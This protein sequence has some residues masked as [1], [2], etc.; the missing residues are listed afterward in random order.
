LAGLFFKVIKQ[1]KPLVIEINVKTRKIPK[2]CEGG[3]RA[4]RNLYQEIPFKE[5]KKMTLVLLR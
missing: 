4:G 2:I 3:V 5:C 1:Q